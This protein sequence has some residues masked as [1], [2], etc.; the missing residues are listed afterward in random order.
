[1]TYSPQLAA[2]IEQRLDVSN[3]LSGATHLST[4]EQRQFRKQLWA[5]IDSHVRGHMTTADTLVWLAAFRIRVDENDLG[6]I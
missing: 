3:V 4:Y 5:A 2:L 6:I 1:M